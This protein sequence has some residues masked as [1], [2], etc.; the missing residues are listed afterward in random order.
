MKRKIFLTILMIAL[1]MCLFAI[2]ASAAV[3]IGDETNGYVYYDLSKNNTFE[4]YDGTATVSTVNRTSEDTDKSTH[5]V[6][7]EVVEYDSDEDGVLEK[8][9]VTAVASQA[10]GST[11]STTHPLVSITI[12]KTVKTIGTHVFRNLTALTTVI[13]KAQGY[14]PVTGETC[15]ISFADAEFYHAYAL[16]YVDMSESNVVKLEK[17]CFESCS[18]LHTV[19]FSPRIKSIAQSFNG[20]TALTTINSIESLETLGTSF[21]GTKISG[22]IKLPNLTSLGDNAFRNT[23][24]TSVD[25]S[26]SSIA[27]IGSHTFNNCDSLI[28]VTLPDT[29]KSIGSN[30]FAG[31]AL[32]E[33]IVLPNGIETISGGAFSSCPKLTAIN[34]PSSIKTIGDSAFYGVKMTGSFVLPNV[35]SIGM[36]AFRET[37]I[38]SIDFTGSTFETVGER[39]FQQCYSLTSVTLPST[40]KTVNQYAF[41]NCT[42]LSSLTVPSTLESLGLRSFN[43]CPITGDFVFNSLSTVSEDAF[44]GAAITSLDFTGSTFTSIGR[45]AFASNTILESVVLP[46]T[47]TVLNEAAFKDCTS[48]TTINIPSGLKSIGA[49]VFNNAPIECDVVIDYLESIGSNAFRNTDI[50]SFVAKDGSITGV[51]VDA[52]FGDSP[53]L[54]YVVFPSSVTAIG[55]SIFHNCSSLEYFVVSDA[56]SSVASNSFTSC[57]KLMSVIVVGNDTSKASSALS[58]WGVAPFSEYD[59]SNATTKTIYYGAIATDD[60]TVY[61]DFTGFDKS[62]GTWDATTNEKTSYDAVVES[63]GYSTKN[64]GNG[65]ATGYKINQESVD[66]YKAIFGGDIKFGIVVFNPSF[67]GETFFDAEGKI[68]AEKGAIQVELVE[69]YST[70]SASV[71][72]FDLSNE[73]HQKL[74]LVFA[75]YAYTKADKSDIDLFQKEYVG[76]Q[77]N[78]VS[79]PMQSK[80]VKGDDVLYTVKLQT[81]T[82]PV[83]ITTGKDGLNAFG[84]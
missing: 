1:C 26:G 50:T 4:G 57:S 2:C 23:A 48:L 19:L 35:E 24:I 37:N 68:N 53:N 51:N 70:L 43:G 18:K 20:C 54:K 21:Y 3:K 58:S 61:A 28:S 56:F 12:P 65:I 13:I 41:E 22:D 67:I 15:D 17:Y 32:L 10:F 75:G 45:Y 80:V 29:V 49:R 83:N 60:A 36:H 81:V 59:P 82:T 62:F 84:A 39:A 69:N 77:E 72:G 9:V 76:T 16:E 66:A 73:A 25:L 5:I 74:E 14:N 46:E 34:L 8:Y 42:S 33:S 71:A 38:T 31:S 64:N 55:N 27:S 7:P 52:E 6:I 79:S 11:G 40:V 63:L 30:A 47:L 78:P 44:R